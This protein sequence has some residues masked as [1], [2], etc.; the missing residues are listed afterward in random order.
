MSNCIIHK[1]L[2]HTCQTFEDYNNNYN[3]FINK[4]IMPNKKFQFYRSL[5]IH[6]DI[7]NNYDLFL[8]LKNKF[9]NSNN[10][11]NL[12]KKKYCQ[13]N[14]KKIIIPEKLKFSL[15][16]KVKIDDFYPSNFYFDLNPKEKFIKLTDV[17]HNYL[18]LFNIQLSHEISLLFEEFTNELLSFKENNNTNKNTM[19]NTISFLNIFYDILNS[20]DYFLLNSIDYKQ[21]MFLSSFAN[22]I[23][24]E[25]YILLIPTNVDTNVKINSDNINNNYLLITDKQFYFKKNDMTVSV[26]YTFD[27]L[28]SE[29]IVYGFIKDKFKKEIFNIKIN[30][31]YNI[32]KNYKF[33]NKETNL[34][35][36]SYSSYNYDKDIEYHKYNKNNCHFEEYYD[37][38]NNIRHIISQC[39]I[40]DDTTGLRYRG[41]YTGTSQ[42]GK[43][44]RK[45]IQ[46]NNE[47][48]YL[49][50]GDEVKVDTLE[51]KKKKNE[52]G[53]IAYKVAKSENGDLR[54]VK[55]FIP[56]DA[57]VVRPID[58]EY[59]INFG[60]E[61]CDKAIVMDIQL[62][63]KDNEISV[64]PEEMIAYSYIH[65]INGS[66]G[67][68]YNVGQEVYPDDF[69]LDEN[70]GCGAGLHFFQ[71]RLTIFKA[72]IDNI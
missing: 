53:F 54:I 25:R 36:N 68:Q 34:I 5:S 38:K 20:G 42:S 8:E 18:T 14:W 29:N 32:K 23:F 63:I 69:N 28:N 65:K 15:E 6:T 19:E 64:V 50:E 60:K 10:S 71:D 12:K 58:E 57:K 37:Y 47:L 33:I 27:T 51:N 1:P 11:Y 49:L 66:N 44:T 45:S 17:I 2:V 56:P 48:K 43:I 31:K 7:T 40:S 21:Y 70:I 3:I 13:I 30:D 62:P 35:L 16:N 59:F 39:M 9:G 61:R 55:L 52:E 41:K 26:K 67:F 22:C 46:I 72:Y 4:K 24:T